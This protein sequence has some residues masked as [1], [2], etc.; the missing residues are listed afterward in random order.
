MNE[1]EEFEFRHRLEQESSAPVILGPDGKGSWF[2]EV[3]GGLASAP[4][5]AYLGI[6]QM[7]PGGL[8][9]IEKNVLQQNKEAAAKAPVSSVIGN[10]AMLAP[11]ALI[12][13]ANTMAGASTIGAV[14]GL[15]N[16]ADSLKERVANTLIGGVSGAGG[17][18]VGNKLSGALTSKL[19][20]SDNTAAVANAL[21]KPKADV[22]AA[23]REAGYVVPPAAANPSWINKRLE[24]IAGKAAV[25]QEVSA[26]NQ[27]VTNALARQAAGLGEDVPLSQQALSGVREA[28]GQPYKEVGSLS[29]IAGQDLEALKQARFDANAYYKHYNMSADPASLAKA[30]EAKSLAGMLDQ[31]LENEATS[32]GRPELINQLKDARTQIA[33]TYD[34]GRAVNPGNGDVS[35]NVIGAL[36]KKGRPLTDELATIGK[37]QQAFPAYMREGAKIPTPGVSK[38]EALAGALLGV[39]GVA[40]GGPM[41]AMAGA[42]PLMSGAVRSMILSKPYQAIMA[43]APEQASPATLRL[44]EALMRKGKGALPALSAQGVLGAASMLE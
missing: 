19:G 10:I 25:G 30:K 18:Y 27:E 5:N 2:D 9:N 1:Q 29:P 41:G 44:V 17:Q 13:W 15:I 33:K 28:A 42:A 37:M 12:P 3:K 4:I 40:I 6:K 26:R 38:S 35:A 39:G 14:T 20:E 36:L 16:P 11:T 23:G 24:S 7:L 8:S 31:S 22:L 21:A 32:A 34:I 43:K